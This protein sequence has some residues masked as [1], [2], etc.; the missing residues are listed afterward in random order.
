MRYTM[1][2]GLALGA[3]CMHVLDADAGNDRVFGDGFEPICGI[4]YPDADGDGFGRNDSAGEFLCGPLPGYSLIGGDCDDTDPATSPAA[5]EFEDGIDNDCN[6]IVDDLPLCDGF[7]A[8]DEQDA[9]VAAR[10]MELCKVAQGPGDWGLLAAAWTL[11]DGAA[12]PPANFHI[13]HGVESGF[14]SVAPRRGDQLLVLSTGAARQ[15]TSPGY[16]SDLSKGYISGHPAGYPANYAVCPGV[17]G[18]QPHDGIALQVW[19]RA[20][21]G[22]NALSFDFRYYT[23]DWPNF[24]CSSFAD[25]LVVQMTPAPDGSPHEGLIVFDSQ[26][27]PPWE[28]SVEACGCAGGPPCAVGGYQFTCPLGTA[29]LAGTMYATHGSTGWLAQPIPVTPGQELVIRFSIYD[30]GDGS[31][32][33]T[34]LIDAFRWLR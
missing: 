14:G 29:P 34:V 4:Y 23:R 27:N 26:F 25:R 31:F 20:P 21:P 17:V 10:A 6:G 11:P 2:R 33:S 24:V 3:M 15:P 19:L 32:D 1:L 13:G 22:A 28:G 18:A 7:I 30:S 8:L 12:P 16:T 5:Y 9:M